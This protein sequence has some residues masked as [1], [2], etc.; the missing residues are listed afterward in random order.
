MWENTAGMASLFVDGAMRVRCQGKG[1]GWAFSWNGNFVLGDRRTASAE[2]TSI[3]TCVKLWERVI[4]N[5]DVKMVYEDKKCKINSE[6]TIGWPWFK[7][8]ELDGENDMGELLFLV[9]GGFRYVSKSK[10][11]FLA[12]LLLRI[13]CRKMFCFAYKLR[14]C[15]AYD[16]R[17]GIS[18][19]SSSN[20]NVYSVYHLQEKPSFRLHNKTVRVL[21]F[22]AFLVIFPIFLR[23]I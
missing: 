18:S 21:L 13:V 2:F 12:Q 16:L 14:K 23:S 3:L 8:A 6:V 7:M 19:L 22:D 10:N 5:G 4:S 9:E 15:S 17:F 1:I 20:R 11:L